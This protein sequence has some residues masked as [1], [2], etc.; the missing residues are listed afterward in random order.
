MSAVKITVVGAGY[1]GCVSAAGF[2]EIGHDVICVDIDA[3]KIAKLNAG[4]VPFYEPGLLDLIGRNVKDGRLRFSTDLKSSV[5]G[6][7]TVFLAV[8]TPSKADGS[9]D[10]SFL[11]E[12]AARV[13]EAADP[14]PPLQGLTVV[15]KS[16]VPVGTA[17][18]LRG[19]AKEKAPCHITIES[20][21]EFL[22]EGDAV[23]DFL[24]PERV[25][26]GCEGGK[27]SHL[28]RIYRP[29]MLRDNRVIVMDNRSAELT[30]Y[31]CNAMLATRVSFMNE[32]ANLCEKVGANVDL[33]RQG[34][35]SDSRIG[36]KFLYPGPGFSG[37]C[38]GK[39]LRAL[40]QMSDGELKIPTAA[41]EINEERRRLM[42][43]KICWALKCGPDETQENLKH[44]ERSMAGK[45]IAIW[46]LSF[47]PRTDDI[48]DAQS[49][50][51]L[52]Q[53]LGF[54]ATVRAYDRAALKNIRQK[55]P[56][57]KYPNLTLVDD[58]YAALDGADALVLMTEWAEFRQP[59][60]AEVA[61][62]MKGRAVFD[63]RN[64]WDPA[65]VGEA[66]FRY[67]G[68]GRPR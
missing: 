38:F 60:W 66:G 53:L 5:K 7:D 49:V 62:R 64:I 32:M 12:A 67:E 45:T 47:K 14:E 33:V 3:E 50:S 58:E 19:L 16:T 27:D 36:S 24:R 22:K 13:F 41:L 54:G 9:A 29:L 44:P 42:C 20:N 48:R 17:D 68:I 21:P 52:E 40:I 56:A 6:R 51:L 1:V 4:E 61:K 57:D 37:S 18:R 11:F 25:I 59:D 23:N 46:G 39:D 2:A 35:G 10:L 26:I 31:A 43:K 28:E 8:G 65:E 63:G 15:V 34:M 55:F 30:K